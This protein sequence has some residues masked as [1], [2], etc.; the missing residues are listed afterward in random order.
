MS[1]K[2]AILVI[3]AIV[4]AALAI[5]GY[6]VNNLSLVYIFK[7]FATLLI[8]VLAANNA[9][10]TELPFAR[11]ICIGILFSLFGDALLIWP[12]KFFLPGLAVFFL[13]HIAYLAAFTR[14]A[15]FPAN[16]PVWMIFLAIAAADFM[17][18]R[19]NLPGGLKLPV[20]LYTVALAS[21]AAQAV[22]RF[23]LLR[24]FPAKLAALG[25]L[26]FLLS[27]SLLGWNRF[28]H[29]RPLAPLLILLPYYTAQ[30]LFA[31]STNPG[32]EWR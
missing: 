12:D 14:G 29:P 5:G 19:P 3:L 9:G 25:A 27:D 30:L 15:R 26:F 24:T 31:L 17:L 13:A 6:L 1:R 20:A 16:V 22:G 2:I 8:L 7:P 11:W 32:G 4:A 10:K 18:L 23:L 21:M 28:G